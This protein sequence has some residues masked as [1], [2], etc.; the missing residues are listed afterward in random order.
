MPGLRQRHMDRTR[1]AI[2][3]AALALFSEQGFIETTVGAIAERA[4]VSRRTFFRYFPA[5]ESVLFHDIDT[6]IQATVD[7]LA[8][9][10]EGES[11]FEALIAALGESAGRC[12]QDVEWRR[13]AWSSP[14]LATSWWARWWEIAQ[15]LADVA[16]GEALVE[17]P[18]GGLNLGGG[19]R[20]GL[21]GLGAGPST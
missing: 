18:S 3:D 19:V 9:R 10:P 2:V 6:Q 13:L 16:Q 11:P 17:F 1:A 4:D 20:V 12:S 5:K 8:A 15:E 14:Q 21:G 7:A